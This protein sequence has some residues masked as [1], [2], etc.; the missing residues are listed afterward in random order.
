MILLETTAIQGRCLENSK[1]SRSESQ[2]L[3]LILRRHLGIFRYGPE[4]VRITEKK[5]LQL[6]RKSS[7]F[8]ISTSFRPTFLYVRPTTDSNIGRFSAG[9][10]ESREVSSQGNVSWEK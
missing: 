6:A 7:W 3:N 8:R 1:N 5:V 4:I 2:D 10:S 9:K